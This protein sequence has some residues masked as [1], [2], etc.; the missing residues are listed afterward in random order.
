MLNFFVAVAL[1]TALQAPDSARD[2]NA[3]RV[4]EL[5]ERARVRRAVPKSDTAMRNYQAHAD[6]YVYFYL[7]RKNTDERTLVR[8]DQVALNIYWAAPSYTKQ[9]IIGMRD[10]SRLPNK[11]YYHLDHLT[12]V[13]DDFGDLIRI[14][15]G[16]EVSAV[17]ATGCEGQR[18]FKMP[19]IVDHQQHG[20]RTDGAAQGCGL[21]IVVTEA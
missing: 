18:V 14:G 4:Q 20:A 11:M 9:H 10:E 17:G 8:V 21:G 1:A 3:Q 5:V 2:W 15:D 13:Q 16:D 6:G 7:D 12:V 19:G